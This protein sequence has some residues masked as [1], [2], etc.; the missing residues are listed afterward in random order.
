MSETIVFNTEDTL[1]GSSYAVTEQIPLFNLVSENDPIL[2]EVLPEFD[3]ANPPVNP[4]EFASSLVETCKEHK[5]YGLSA[6]QCGF[7][8]RVFVM[9]SGEQYVAFFNPELINISQQESHLVEGCLSFPLLGLSITRPAEIGV[10][11]Q[12]FNG[13]WKGTTLS[14]ISARCFLHELDHMNGILYTSKVKP[15]A[16]QTGMKKRDKLLKMVNK[17]NKN[18]AKIK[19]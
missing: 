1:K 15:L 6:N 12:D 11:Y 16:L 13:E 3:F 2:R 7:R 9:G 5:G 8:H 19:K 17:M 10:R 4:I 14:G 18:L